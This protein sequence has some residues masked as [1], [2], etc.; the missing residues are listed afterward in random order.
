MQR[1]TRK[2][3]TARKLVP[4]P[5]VD[6]DS[7]RV[8]II[9]FGSSDPAVRE[10]RHQLRH[11]HGLETDY[12]RLRAYPFSSELDTFVE[13]HDRVYVVEQNRDAQLAALVRLHLSAELGPRVR[14]V[15]H[16]HGLPLDARSTTDELLALEGR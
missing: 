15:A 9:A 4:A 11:E 13:R 16:I 10:S 5:V 7:A 12:L 14:S 3:E 8:G 6:G 2:L 1:L